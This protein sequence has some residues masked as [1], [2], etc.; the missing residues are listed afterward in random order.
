MFFLFS[1]FSQILGK[2]SHTSQLILLETGEAISQDNISYENPVQRFCHLNL[3]AVST[4]GSDILYWDR[5]T[6][7]KKGLS[8]I[9]NPQPEPSNALSYTWKGNSGDTF[10]CCTQRRSEP[11]WS[12]K[13]PSRL[14]TQC[15][16]LDWSWSR[17]SLTEKSQLDPYQSVCPSEFYS[18]CR[19]QLSSQLS[20]QRYSCQVQCR[21]FASKLEPNDSPAHQ[22][23]M[24][25]WRLTSWS[26][27]QS[28]RADAAPESSSL[29]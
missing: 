22:W 23:K 10:L 7:H 25:G 14:P 15:T 21:Q 18:S 13:P 29:H 9:W 17:P 3:G 28:P 4:S 2:N 1:L 12:L 8:S 19:V 24:H 27:P 16:Y 5:T 26:P 6:L 20:S 11:S